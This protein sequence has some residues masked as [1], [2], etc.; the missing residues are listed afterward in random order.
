MQH[1]DREISNQS[2]ESNSFSGREDNVADSITRE[3]QRQNPM[4]TSMNDINI[5]D[6]HGH[7]NSQDRVQV[8]L[9]TRRK[10]SGREDSKIE[11]F[12]NN[13]NDVFNSTNGM[14][15]ILQNDLIL[16]DCSHFRQDGELGFPQFDQEGHINPILEVNINC[17]FL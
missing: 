3:R 16:A 12:Y 15:P 6:L 2:V 5:Y 11:Q 8:V 13:D 17:L 10:A 9:P 1:G 14:N 7:C 4:D